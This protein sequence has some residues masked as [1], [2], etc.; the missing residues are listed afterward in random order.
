MPK[1]PNLTRMLA[2]ALITMTS[3]ASAFAITMPR[4]DVQ[5]RSDVLR[6]SDH[7]HN[8]HR[9]GHQAHGYDGTY[10]DDDGNGMLF[11][12]FVMGELTGSHKTTARRDVD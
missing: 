1:R 2:V 8:C 7:H 6:V 5:V 4:L 9:R 3:A 10:S 11:K 12:S